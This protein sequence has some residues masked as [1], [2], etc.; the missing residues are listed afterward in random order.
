[1]VRD[2]FHDYLVAELKQRDEISSVSMADNYNGGY[3][4]GVVDAVAIVLS[5]YAAFKREIDG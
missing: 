1:M 2:K 3:D 4:R 5:K